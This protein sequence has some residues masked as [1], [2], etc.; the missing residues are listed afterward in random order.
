[1]RTISVAAIVLL[2]ATWMV[3]EWSGPLLNS[4]TPAP[5][6]VDADHDLDIRQVYLSGLELD[7][8]WR[9]YR[10]FD[11]VRCEALEALRQGRLSLADA[12]VKVR[13]E[14][15]A[16]QPILLKNLKELGVGGNQRTDVEN[17]AQHLLDRLAD[18]REHN[19]ASP[20]SRERE[21]EALP[22]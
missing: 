7:R 8:Q 12:A 20:S 14:A 10:R 9:D 1:M 16:S 2:A 3:A 17:I 13:D 19:A 11:Q 22:Q 15:L 21:P 4:P 18:E 6:S 5:A